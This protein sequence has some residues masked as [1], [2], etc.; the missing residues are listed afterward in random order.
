MNMRIPVP[1]ERLARWTAG[2]DI[3]HL[4]TASCL[5]CV[6]SV[7]RGTWH[8]NPGC[9]WYAVE[10]VFSG[11]RRMVSHGREDNLRRQFLLKL[12]GSFETDLLF[13]KAPLDPHFS[14]RGVGDLW[15]MAPRVGETEFLCSKD[16]KTA[17][18]QRRIKLFG[19][20]LA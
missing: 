10:S 2:R 19:G 16:F 18:N 8:C 15:D 14:V 12:H 3:V 17:A 4:C 9:Y 13:E 7:L 1:S 11:T 20:I 5:L 6:Q